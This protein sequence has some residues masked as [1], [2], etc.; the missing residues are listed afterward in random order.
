MTR[1]KD[2]KMNRFKN[3][4]LGAFLVEH[5]PKIA[6]VIIDQTDPEKLPRPS[7]IK[8]VWRSTSGIKFEDK[9]RFEELMAFYPVDGCDTKVELMNDLIDSGKKARSLART[10]GM[11]VLYLLASIGLVHFIIELTK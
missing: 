1:E 11:I 3:T 2:K 5:F 7:L 10:M 8:E 4:E 6:E 9:M